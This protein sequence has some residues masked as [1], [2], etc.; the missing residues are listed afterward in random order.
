MISPRSSGRRPNCDVGPTNCRR[1]TTGCGGTCGLPLES[2]KPSSASALPDTAP[3]RVAWAFRPCE[4]LG[5]DLLNLFP[6]G[7]GHLGL[8]L[9]DVSGHGVPASLLAVAVGHALNP[10]GDQAGLRQPAEVLRRVNARLCG[11]RTGSSLPCSTRYSIWTLSPSYLRQRRPSADR[12]SC[13]PGAEAGRSWPR[14]G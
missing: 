3:V 4:E 5:G 7:D 10:H 9:L 8:Y 2:S 11:D 1:P 13:R 14:A 12:S 6:I